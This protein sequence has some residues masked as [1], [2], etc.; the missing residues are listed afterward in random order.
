M[1]SQETNS[2]KLVL[3]QVFFIKI[4]NICRAAECSKA[5]PAV[6][7]GAAAT[8]VHLRPFVGR[9]WDMGWQICASI[10]ENSSELHRAQ[11]AMRSQLNRLRG[12]RV[13][14]GLD[15]WFPSLPVCM[16]R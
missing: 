1:C 9:G 6:S 8:R 10:L 16:T 11:R 13:A 2:A 14:G 12:D 3:V 4:S 15:K 7:D 5:V